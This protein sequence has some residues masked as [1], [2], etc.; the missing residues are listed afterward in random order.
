MYQ[1]DSSMKMLCPQRYNAYILADK[2][3]QVVL[4]LMEKREWN[5]AEV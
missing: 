3:M 4:K 1:A 5:A 2:K